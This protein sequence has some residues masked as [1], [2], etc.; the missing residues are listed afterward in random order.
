MLFLISAR[1]W[2]NET[3]IFVLVACSL[4]FYG[5]WNPQYL[6][7]LIG[8]MAVNYKLG[9]YLGKKPDK[10][11]LTVGIAC[12]LG[13]IAYFK[14]AGF[15]AFN[16]NLIA[17]TSYN[18]GNII[19]PLA[20]SFFTFQQIAYLVDSYRGITKEYSPLHYAL[21]VSFSRNLLPARSFTI[22][23]CFHNLNDNQ[24]FG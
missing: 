24:H 11:L 22:R 15:I 13:A 5:W 19:L 3:A 6:V 2:G 18:L 7:L 20:I 23:T 21:F 8:S 1:K 14:Y 9:S 17:G 4:F 12:N 10:K 16:I